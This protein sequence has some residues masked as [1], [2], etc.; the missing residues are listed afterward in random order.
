[1]FVREILKSS[2]QVN[3]GRKLGG[4]FM[5]Q[6]HRF[7]GYSILKPEYRILEEFKCMA[8]QGRIQY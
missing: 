8:A 3:F 4:L 5:F 7:G 1:M 6:S 2:S